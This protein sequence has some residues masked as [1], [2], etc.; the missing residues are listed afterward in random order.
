LKIATFNIGNRRESG[1]VVK[2]NVKTILVKLKNGKVI[3]RHLEKHNV[4]IEGEENGKQ[5]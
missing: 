2:F 3:K 5:M 4:Y 1:E